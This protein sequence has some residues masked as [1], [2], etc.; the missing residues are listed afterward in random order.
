MVLDTK[1]T[2]GN[3]GGRVCGMRR[4][5]NSAITRRLDEYTAVSIYQE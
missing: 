3:V 4:V 2:C 5:L 1:V